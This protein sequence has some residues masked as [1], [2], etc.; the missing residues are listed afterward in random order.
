MKQLLRIAAL[1]ISYGVSTTLAHAVVLFNNGGPDQVAGLETSIAVEAQDFS[2]GKNPRQSYTLTD[3]HFWTL[4]RAADRWDGTLEWFI[5]DDASGQPAA[6][7]KASGN[8]LNVTRTATGTALPD[9]L[10]GYIEYE[11]SFDLDTPITLQGAVPYW[12][13]LHLASDYEFQRGVFWESTAGGYGTDSQ[14]SSYGDLTHWNPY[15]LDDANEL[16]FYLTGRVPE[17]D[18]Y[19]MLLAGLGLLWLMARRNKQ[20]QLAA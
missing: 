1:L 13:G 20:R 6:T 14:S 17:P 5:F 9:T 16:A 7:T 11:W 4:D 18:T 12:F 2:P 15:G 3:A 10:P 8:G 19:T